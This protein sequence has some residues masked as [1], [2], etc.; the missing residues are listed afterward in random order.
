MITPRATRVFRVPHLRAYQRAIA[1]LTCWQPP[2]ARRDTVVLVPTA[3]AAEALRRTLE[4]LVLVD[5]W[6]PSPAQLADA[7]R[8]PT[9]H[10]TCAVLPDVCTRDEWYERLAS[11]LDR[12]PR[13]LSS[14][15][16]EV[17]FREAARTAIAEGQA[18]PFTVRPG[19]VGEMLDLYDGLLRR[20]RTVERFEEA[21]VERLESTAEID[22]G[23]RRLL[24]QTRFLGAAFRAYRTAIGASGACDEHALR[25][26][27]LSTPVRRPLRQ[28]VVTVGD[29][30]LD[31]S[32]LWR[33]DFN[34]LLT[35][36]DLERVD[37]VATET[38]LAA[39]WYERLLE[40]FPEIEVVRLASDD[41]RMPIVET[42]RATLRST[43]DELAVRHFLVRDREEEVVM[44]ARDS[45][46]TTWSRGARDEGGENGPS[47]LNRTAFVFERPLPYLYLAR[48]VLGA[49]HVPHQMFDALPFATEPFAS[50]FDLVTSVT[51]LNWTRTS[52][53]GLLRSPFVRVPGVGRATGTDV[54]CLD[55]DLERGQ[56]LGG[57]DLLLALLD[58]LE[59]RDGSTSDRSSAYP[60]LLHGVRAV[61]ERLAPFE[62]EALA[63]V[64]LAALI[65]V[66][67]VLLAVPVEI[68]TDVARHV[69]ARDALVG[70][71]ES[72]RQAHVEHGDRPSSFRDVVMNVRRWIEGQTFNPR[73]GTEG[74][75][76]LDASAARYGRFDTV[77]L[78]GLVEGEWQPGSA[79]NIFYPSSLLQPFGW[80][81]DTARQ[82]GA[83][84]HFRDLVMLAERRVRVSTFTLE[85]ETVVRASPLLEELTDAP[86]E[87]RRVDEGAERFMLSVEAMALD[88]LDPLRVEG[89]QAR[90]LELRRAAAKAAAAPADMAGTPP[91]GPSF[92]SRAYAVTRLE[93]YL[94]CPFRYFAA[95]VLGLD[96]EPRD[97]A[98]LSPMQRGLVMHD[99][100]EAF[101]ARWHADGRGAITAAT[102]D[103][104]RAAFADLVDEHLTRVPAGD[105]GVERA[106]LLGSAIAT[107]FGEYV[108]RLELEQAG[109]IVER[110]V[111]YRVDGEYVVPAPDGDRTIRLRG[112]ADRVDLTSRG[113]F[114]VYDYKSSRAPHSKVRLQLPVY[115]FC[116]ERKL[117]GHRGRNWEV[118]S[119]AYL[120]V[121]ENEGVVNVI[122]AKTPRDRALH[123]GLERLTDTV[124]R[125]ER[126][127]YPVR[128]VE[129]FRCTFCPYPSVCRKDYVG[130]E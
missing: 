120:A 56:F 75:Q 67:G 55:V 105:R 119:A 68:G 92:G 99:I 22:R 115:A 126:R 116:A 30:D 25:D 45:L 32:G 88:R 72:L 101:F 5:H 118:E 51:L 125:I 48:M 69:R 34:L 12:R 124:T 78:A 129:P 102:I 63:S 71:L 58:R 27:L 42:P 107:G 11:R 127:E 84:A 7:V 15:E 65:D 81:R 94:Q 85:D 93:A 53:V 14:Y 87:T 112:V 113:T 46:A 130:D 66:V 89:L 59:T 9:V 80:P 44:L 122:G 13:R 64:H 18:P 114:R 70:I 90:W 21:T 97:E 61:A 10:G 4:E 76:L 79:R 104:A 100:F 16:R 31:P 103:D 96:E 123:D 23:A 39:G 17:I 29:Q 109:D 37:I 117:A 47:D 60:A 3:S 19:L 52:L 24:Q 20:F 8:E 2:L 40:E 1:L 38:V 108:F 62:H 98:G 33:A 77:H 28:V 26:V 73:S 35:I 128:P 82:Q 86:L 121:R 74:V 54:S 43:A 50:A 41:E 6:S 106:R 111:E 83:R 36:P 110:L 57:R 49:A 95:H 91:D